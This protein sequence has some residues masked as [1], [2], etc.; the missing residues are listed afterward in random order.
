M[1]GPGFLNQ[2]PTVGFFLGQL[3]A[4]GESF[5]LQKRLQETDQERYILC[6][7]GLRSVTVRAA[8]IR[9]TYYYAG[10]LQKDRC[11]C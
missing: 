8:A 3:L 6:L 9:V 5:E 7:A 1:K 2:V 4:E 11:W 10:D